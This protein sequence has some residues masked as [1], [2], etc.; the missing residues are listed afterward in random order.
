MN[1]DRRLKKIE[2]IVNT[3][4]T[5]ETRKYAQ[6]EAEHGIIR[7]ADIEAR[8][9]ELVS[10]GWTWGGFLKKIDGD[11]LILPSLRKERATV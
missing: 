11:S 3:D 1:I 9:T 4:K 8:T 10:Q 6:F 2:G 5:E 7:E